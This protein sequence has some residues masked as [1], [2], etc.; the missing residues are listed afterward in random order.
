MAAGCAMDDDLEMAH[1]LRELGYSDTEAELMLFHAEMEQREW[2]DPMLMQRAG[3]A[4]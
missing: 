2:N 3:E 1:A 4:G